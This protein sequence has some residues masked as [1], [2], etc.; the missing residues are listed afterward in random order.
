M[1]LLRDLNKL[2]QEVVQNFNDKFDASD[3]RIPQ[4]FKN[5]VKRLNTFSI[6]Y[7]DYS[8]VIKG[9]GV[10]S[11]DSYI[12]NQSFFMASFFIEYSYELAKYKQKILPW[13][14]ASGISSNEL[15]DFFTHERDFGR[16]DV[17]KE[18]DRF[19]KILDS[20]D[21]HETDRDYLI[22]FV[23]DYDW[24]S[25]SK[26]IERSDFFNSPVLKIMGLS[27]SSNS[28]MAL[29]VDHL[30]QHPEDNNLLL[31]SG[32]KSHMSNIGNNQIIFYGAPGTGKSHEIKEKTNG[33]AVV[34]TTFHPDSDYSTFVGAYKPT[35]DDVGTKVVPVVQNNGII[36]E[37]EGTYKEK[38]IV[39]K[40]IPQAFLKA[41]LG[42]WKKYAQSQNTNKS[43]SSVT[44]KNNNDSWTI[45][46]V[47]DE[48]ASYTKK[49][50]SPIDAFKKS[51]KR[52]WTRITESDDPDNYVVRTDEMYDAAVCLWYK[53]NNSI[54]VTFDECWQ[55]VYNYL[56]EGNSIEYKPGPRQLY[57][58]KLQ[59][60]TIDI[61]SK[62]SAK[63]KTIKVY[64]EN[65]SSKGSVQSAIAS[66]LHEY[67]S[68]FEEAWKKLKENVGGSAF[69]NELEPQFLIIEEIN[70][71]NCAQIFGD[72]FQ[73]LDRGNNGFS[74]YPIE[75]D[76]DLQQEI[77][78]AFKED[79][80]YRLN[81]KI[82]IEGVVEG[83]TSNYGANL[84]E[85]VQSGRILLLPKNLYIWATMNTSDQSLFPIDSAFKRR[86]DWKYIKI[87]DHHEEDYKIVVGEEAPIPWYGFIKKINDIIAS[88]TSSADKQLGYFFCKAD[89]DGCI[90]AKTFVSKVI[91]YLW[92]DVFKDYGFEDTSL[93]RYIDEKDGKEKD[94]TFPDFY[95]EDGEEVNE[96]RLKD[97]LDK[98]MNWK[99]DK[100]EQK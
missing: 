20:V 18:E 76:T 19:V 38:K 96:T 56:K 7:N 42:A 73:L 6:V 13:I 29:I 69:S 15:T 70:R 74:E 71:G 89:K 30:T 94:L 27:A 93:F 68:D 58:V 79:K 28:V 1:E 98:V 75:A 37:K 87:K 36:F 33:K 16:S 43:A 49:T 64:F 86:W 52:T 61:F 14:T 97:F 62:S 60:D 46:S 51:V 53:E 91:F 25:G 11:K 5:N 34:R 45:I 67:S 72:L 3:C 22:K 54:D 65:V 84:S 78:R 47:D 40:F 17:Q 57:V 99:K 2:A 32:G 92:N 39:Y 63:K 50:T 4:A 66:K 83:Y 9:D 81:G 12:P 88:M 21:Y 100:E 85:D 35:M 82:N 44:V 59:N 77:E 10:R 90:D 80:D 48:C 55:G 24:W 26:T 41:Y 23:T 95:D 31:N 8:V